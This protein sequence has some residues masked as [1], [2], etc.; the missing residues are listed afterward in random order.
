MC[1]HV[2]AKQELGFIIFH[3]G[4]KTKEVKNLEKTIAVVM[5]LLLTKTQSFKKMK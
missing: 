1:I 5:M 4:Q 3:L 2:V